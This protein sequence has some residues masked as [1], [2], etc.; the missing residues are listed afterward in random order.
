M[1]RCYGRPPLR[2][3]PPASSLK[4]GAPPPPPAGIAALC[5]PPP[6]TPPA[7]PVRWAS[8][9]ITAPRPGPS[10]VEQT[11]AAIEAAGFPPP[12]IFAEPGADVPPHLHTRLVRWPRQ[13]G[14]Y[15]QN[16]AALA[17]IYMAMGTRGFDAVASFEDDVEPM[18]GLARYL[19]AEV[20][21]PTPPERLGCLSLY[22]PAMHADGAVGWHRW[23]QLLWGS[24]A[25]V[26]S[27]E[28]VR[29]YLWENPRTH[30]LHRCHPSPA[31]DTFFDVE[32]SRWCLRVRRDMWFARATGGASL[33]RHHG[34][35]S[36]LWPG[37]QGS[38][39]ERAFAGDLRTE[40]PAA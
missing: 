2:L 23:E 9:V 21:W 3:Q 32:F 30:L 20:L 14:I 17:W 28:A 25:L 11:I 40:A 18:P 1:N 6:R 33:T 19:E 10:R 37:Q 38:H 34:D 27:R 8:Y 24:Q 7:E 31:I 36:S 26:L 5:P 35:R 4:P 39:F 16:T 29:A 15:Q 12:F 13:T 22:T